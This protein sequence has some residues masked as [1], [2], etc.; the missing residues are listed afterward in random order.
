MVDFSKLGIEGAVLIE[1]DCHHDGRGFFLETYQRKRYEKFGLGIEFVQDNRSRSAKN[2]L[3]GM[4]YQIIHPQGH[5]VYVT[6]GTVFDVGLDLRKDSSTFKNWI[7]VTLSAESQQQLYLP[8]GVAHGFCALSENVEIYY[9][10]TD[11]YYPEEEGGVLWSDPDIGIKWPI[12][13]PIINDNDARFLPLKD[14]AE[15]ELPQIGA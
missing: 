2:V 4:H 13:D 10:C 11:Y 12:E 15:G 5:L 9:K 14:I 1:L 8:P 3:R 6:S 7:G